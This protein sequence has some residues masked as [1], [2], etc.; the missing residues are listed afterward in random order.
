MVWLLVLGFSEK[1]T[2][3]SSVFYF[4]FSIME[5]TEKIAKDRNNLICKKAKPF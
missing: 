2:L 4:L 3:L 1:L 5:H